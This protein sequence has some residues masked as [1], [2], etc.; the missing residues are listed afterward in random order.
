MT[1]NCDKD[2]SLVEYIQQSDPSCG[3][4]ELQNCQDN[5][6][7]VD[8][9]DEHLNIG[10]PSI[11]V[12]KLLGIHEQGTLF[13]V[14]GNGNPIASS[15]IAGYGAS[16]AFNG[17]CGVW[18]SE[19]RTCDT[20][21]QSYIGYDF[22]NVDS[23][24]HSVS[25]YARGTFNSKH[26][27]FM[28]IQQGAH[29][30]NR[31]DKV[32]VERS[33]DGSSWTGVQIIT[34]PNNS[35]LNDIHIRGSAASRFWRLRPVAFRGTDDDYWE[36]TRI[37]MHE[38]E[39]TSLT[40]LQYDGGFLENRDR[41]YAQTAVAVKMFYDIAEQRTELGPHAMRLS[42]DTTS[43]TVSFKQSLQK[44]GRP[45]VIGDILDLP[46]EIQYTPTLQAVRRYLEVIDV[47]WSSDGYTPGWQPTLQ[48][49]TAVPM[50]A[51]QETRDIQPLPSIDQD[52]VLNLND[53]NV[54][55]LS[56]IADRVKAQAMTDLPQRGKNGHAIHTFSQEEVDT[57]AAQGVNINVLNH[58]QTALY[59]EDAMPPN[60]EHYTEGNAWPVSPSDGDWHR[61][62]YETYDSTI[63][64]RLFKYSG[65]KSQW[66]YYETD[67]RQQ[68]EMIKPSIA[69]AVKRADKTGSY[70]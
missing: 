56:E 37:E 24:T 28:R 23:D 70:K 54:N 15:N 5:M 18:R 61:L 34:L 53:E 57:A 12:F 27:T 20:A 47:T 51:G 41:D 40:N 45:I 49:I 69:E 9:V 3:N 30:R 6:F 16:N 63:P 66:M 59:I 8:V 10:A 26:I 46:P 35:G 65:K 29:E 36:V 64:A 39:A 43:L 25:Q 50:I 52:G 48:R 67:R 68:F 13:D 4:F 32:R 21:L 58:N 44:L 11:N 19:F 7:I 60:N 22:G 2:C 38:Y 31:A 33:M 14:T 1:D 55:D 42:D 17:L 62:T